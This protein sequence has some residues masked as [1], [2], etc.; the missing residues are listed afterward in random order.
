M[1]AIT[2]AM[3]AALFFLIN[4]MLGESDTVTPDIIL[5]KNMRPEMGLQVVKADFGI[6]WDDIIVINGVKPTGESVIAGDFIVFT[7]N[8][9]SDTMEMIY[10][11]T[12][13]L[14][15]SWQF[16]TISGGG[17]GSEPE[18]PPTVESA[19]TPETD[20]YD[21]TNGVPTSSAS[22]TSPTAD[23]NLL[24][25]TTGHRIGD[26]DTYHTPSISG[27]TLQAVGYNDPSTTS[28][29]RI[30]AIFTKL[31]VNGESLDL[32]IN[33]GADS[34]CDGTAWA[35]LQE[36]TGAASYT[37]VDDGGS[38]DDGTTSL[39]IPSSPL[40]APG[41]DNILAFAGT[42]W[43]GNPT[44]ESYTNGFG[45]LAYNNDIGT[46]QGLTAYTYTTSGDIS[47]DTTC[48]WTTSM[49]SAGALVLFSCE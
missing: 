37:K 27:W 30:V 39:G 42:V 28:D 17:G 7:G 45:D 11:P 1:V 6:N 36:F 16:G 49:P 13:A 26:P 48:S 25:L 43:R 22:F 15:G 46:C 21:L 38:F 24:V 2:V 14:I 4:N 41:A 19:R 32:S 47:W 12:N 44:A 40:P 31:S 29:R 9:T 35:I 5:S 33:W 34:L 18:L 10:G 20:T 23:G 3:A 8:E